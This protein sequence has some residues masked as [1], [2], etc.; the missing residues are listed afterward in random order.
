MKFKL[1]KYF[2]TKQKINKLEKQVRKNLKLKLYDIYEEESPTEAELD[3]LKN[4]S[5]EIKL[6]EQYYE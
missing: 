4:I 6:F 2:A 5:E 3:E 1:I